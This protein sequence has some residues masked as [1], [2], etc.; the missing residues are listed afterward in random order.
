M[1]YSL[2]G[3]IV[4]MIVGQ[5]V[6]W[7]TGGSSQKI[8]EQLLIPFFQSANYKLRQACANETKYVT[9]DQ[10]LIEMMQMKTSS[11]EYEHNDEVIT[12]G[13]EG[14]SILNQ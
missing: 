7:M 5:V 1:C 6:S 14:K 8:D 11:R 10:M 4:S 2:I 3:F 12:N 13:T 9:I